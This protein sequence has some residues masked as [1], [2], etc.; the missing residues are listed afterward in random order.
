M[1]GGAWVIGRQ[2]GCI[3]GIFEKEV[4]FGVKEEGCWAAFVF[5]GL[6]VSDMYS[7]FSAIE[8]QFVMRWMCSG[9]LG[10]WRWG[11]GPLVWGGVLVTLA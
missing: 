3:G 1:D 5:R 11:R 9:W 7:C 6:R 8:S 2:I 10:L 4:E